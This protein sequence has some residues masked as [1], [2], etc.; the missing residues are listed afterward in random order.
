M[1]Q[2]YFQ[3][4]EYEKAAVLFEKLYDESKNDYYFNKLIECLTS[5][6]RFEDAEKNVKKELKKKPGELSLYVNYGSILERQFKDAEAED[7]YKEAIKKLTNDQFTIIKLAN[8]FSG[9]TKY[10]LAIEAYERGAKLLNN[11]IIFAYNLATLYQMKGEVPKMIEYYLVSLLENPDRQSSIQAMFQRSFQQED[12]TELQTQLYA[13][14]QERQDAPELIEMLTWAFLQ[15]KDYKNALRQARALDKRLNENGVRV[16]NL[17]EIA[18]NDKDYDSA[19]AAYDY[20]VLEKG[21]ASPFYLDAKRQSL[22]CSRHKLVGGFN[23]SKEELRLLEGQYETFLNEFGR[24]QATA[25]IIMELAELEGFYLNDLDKA[26]QNLLEIVEMPAN[27][28]GFSNN[29]QAEAKIKLGDFYLIKGEIW[30][31]TLLYSQVDKAIPDDILGHEARYRNAKLS[32]YNGNF[33]WAQAQFGVL[34]ASTSKLIANDALDL[35]VFIMDNLGLDSTPTAMVLYAEADLLVFQNKFEEAFAKL[36]SISTLFPQHSLEDDVYYLE[37]KIHSKRREYEK[38]AHKY[39]LII[40]KYKDEIRADNALFELAELYE[41][42]NQLNNLERAKELYE[43]IFTD[44]SGSTF[45]VE[46][47]KRFRILRGDKI[48]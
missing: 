25:A 20:I 41:N 38:A 2:Q 35:S 13:L 4:G 43:K 32:Y 5:L 18:A 44:Y 36:D 47:R 28:P 46:A 48:Q 22:R 19:I 45:A 17:A 40:E 29:I 27:M 3:N 26:I 8:A 39:N 11:P 31:A 15:K 21:T 7:Q 37:A 1:A 6:E 10:D 30:E 42:P 16:Y 23:Y 14:L 24:N 33:E 9:L 34:K 12:Y